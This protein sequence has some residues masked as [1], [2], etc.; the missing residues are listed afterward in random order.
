M[1]VNDFFLFCFEGGCPSLRRPP[2]KFTFQKGGNST[3][4]A[5]AGAFFT[6][7]VRGRQIELDDLSHALL[8]TEHTYLALEG[9]SNLLGVLGAW[10]VGRLGI[11]VA[12]IR[13]ILMQRSVHFP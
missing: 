4:L 12:Y 1:I 13:L 8:C 11:G 7:A 9:T 10:A 5:V 2:C 6:G 3:I